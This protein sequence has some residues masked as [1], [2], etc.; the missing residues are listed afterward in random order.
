GRSPGPLKGGVMLD[1]WLRRRIL[2]W[3][4][5]R[6][7]LSKTYR[8]IVCTGGIFADTRRLVRL[9]PVPLRYM[10]DER[11]FRKY[12]WIEAYVRRA[13]EDAR[14]E[15]FKVRADGITVLEELPS[16]AG[17]WDARAD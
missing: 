3:G 10:D 4:K 1:T 8:E 6:P 11:V 9:Y 15:S 13:P 2:I 5:T 16:V 12:Q 14:P 17:N 7:E